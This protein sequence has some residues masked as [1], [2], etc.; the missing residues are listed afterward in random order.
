[1][2]KKQKMTIALVQWGIQGGGE[3]TVLPHKPWLADLDLR[4]NKALLWGT[5]QVQGAGNPAEQCSDGVGV[6]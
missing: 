3:W 6:Q 1:M 2:R 5:G 4:G